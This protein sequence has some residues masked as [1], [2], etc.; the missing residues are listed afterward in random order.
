VINIG[1]SRVPGTDVGLMCLM[2]KFSV[3]R[4]YG[5]A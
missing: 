4:L 3:L 1:S 5:I 2:L